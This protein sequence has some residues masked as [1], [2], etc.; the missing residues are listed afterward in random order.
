MDN[1]V[2]AGIILLLGLGLTLA[3][4]LTYNSLNPNSSL[5]NGF[6][7]TGTPLENNTNH[8]DSDFF[9]DTQ[10][11][12]SYSIYNYQSSSSSSLSPGPSPTPEPTPNI[13]SLF[14]AYVKS[15]FPQTGIPG[16]AIV[17]VKNE[18]IVYM[19]CFGVKDVVSGAPVTE[20][21]LF[22]LASCSKA[23]T[24]TNIAQ[25]VDQGLMTW[26][27]TVIKY[28]PK[29]E[30]FQLYDP[31]VTDSITIRDL[32][33]H[34]SGLP[35]ECGDINGMLFNDTFPEILHK[36]R[37]VENNTP[38]RSTY[39]Y[40]TLMYALAG[41]C[42]ARSSNTLWSDLIK[43]DL[44]DPLG[45]NTATTTLN[46]Y[47][48]SPDHTSTYLRLANGT[49]KQ[50]GPNGA[51][52]DAPSGNIASSIKE[53]VNWLKFQIEDT[54]MYN[55][56][57]IVSKTNLDE[58]H[59]GQIYTDHTNTT[60]YGFGW[61]VLNGNLYH[62]GSN[63]DGMTIVGVYPSKGM[64]IVVLLNENNFGRPYGPALQKKFQD[65][66]DGDYT[67]DPWPLYR[68]ALGPKPNPPIP[69][70]IDSLALSSYVG[71][72]N[73]AFY[74]NI[75]ITTDSNILTCYYGNNSQGFNLKHW[76]GDVFED[77]N[78][79]G[80]LFNFTDY[81][82]NKYQNLTVNVFTDYTTQPTTPAEFNRTN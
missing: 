80:S 15:T 45:M 56:V 66:L 69:P 22:Y 11:F 8:N 72:Y 62:S 12:K 29:T 78:I 35:N 65:L 26:N 32:L 27:D 41:E 50:Y 5:N 2:L 73:N 39:N 19:N 40:Q 77:P 7:G 23:F 82:T 21:T 30:E 63:G 25:L 10:H 70:I 58:T 9:Q 13:I 51:E 67:S 38:F 76:N 55:G 31:A 24:S 68:D 79:P 75:N 28:Y 14:D 20:D 1:K 52:Y 3:G 60:M 4:F 49:L 54:G 59:T 37:Y 46:D 16:G 17:I 6:I 44:L 48:N 47:L 36:F 74:G 43:K 81:Q 34:R 64:G 18:Q 42:A 57:Q 71:V 33:L 53:I 61:N